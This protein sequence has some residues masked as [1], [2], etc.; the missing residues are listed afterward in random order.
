MA[1]PTQK[2]VTEGLRETARIAAAMVD[3]DVL[4]RV[5]SERAMHHLKN[6]DPKFRH[7]AGDYYDVDHASFLLAKKTL[8][9]LQRLVDFPC[10]S[11]LWQV[12]PGKED[13]VTLVV[14]NGSLHRYYQWAESTHEMPAEMRECVSGGEVTVAP[15][16]GDR[17]TVLAPVRDSL[18]DVVGLVELTSPNPKS[19]TMAPAWS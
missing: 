6:P 19:K 17:I 7:M 3:G 8:L 13:H 14:Q 10:D 15:E 4:K 18:G 9:R 12:V 5:I 11:S 1:R 16:D 2:K